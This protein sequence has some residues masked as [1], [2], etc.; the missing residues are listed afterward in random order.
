M[1]GMVFEGTPEEI[2]KS[3]E[4]LGAK[5]PEAEAEATEPERLAV[6]DYAVVIDDTSIE[7]VKRKGVVLSEVYEVIEVDDS[8]VPHRGKR[9]TGGGTN[10]F[11]EGALR[12][13]TDEEVAEAKCIAA[14]AEQLAKMKANLEEVFAQLNSEDVRVE[15]ISMERAPTEVRG[16]PIYYGSLDT[17]TVTIRARNVR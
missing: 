15:E 5:F 17:F 8:L 9:I 2:R 3:M 14:E 16:V 10:W 6:G 1:H 7:G 12:K 13:A 4:L 11:K